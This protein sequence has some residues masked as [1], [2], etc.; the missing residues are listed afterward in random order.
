M[1]VAEIISVTLNPESRVEDRDETAN[2]ETLVPDPRG[3]MTPSQSVEQQLVAT[4]R[5]APRVAS[6]FRSQAFRTR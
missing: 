2:D 1:N 6:Q 4:L 3:G 5:D